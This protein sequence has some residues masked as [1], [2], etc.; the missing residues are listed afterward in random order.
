MST[1]IEASRGTWINIT[2]AELENMWLPGISNRQ[3]TLP[4]QTG[5][6]GV[7]SQERSNSIIM[8]Q[9]EPCETQP[10]HRKP[11]ESLRPGIE[12]VRR[13]Q[14]SVTVGMRL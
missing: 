6:W 10:D 13:R 12:G 2:P 9:I 8:C 1:E 14:S 11:D 4:W 7:A 5:L 3:L